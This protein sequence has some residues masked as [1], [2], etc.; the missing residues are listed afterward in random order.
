MPDREQALLNAL[1][2]IFGA[3]KEDETGGIN[4]SRLEEVVMEA[5]G[6]VWTLGY[7]PD[8]GERRAAV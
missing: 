2:N 5:R 6:T 4:L 3:A 1:V 7:D 8:T